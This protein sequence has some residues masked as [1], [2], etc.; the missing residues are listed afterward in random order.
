MK[1]VRDRIDT[2]PWAEDPR[3][4]A[5]LRAEHLGWVAPDSPEYRRLLRAKLLEECAELLDADQRGDPDAVLEEAADVYEVLRAMLVAIYPGVIPGTARR[6]L[7]NAVDRK[8]AERGGFFQG[9]TWSG[10]ER[11]GHP[12]TVCVNDTNGDGD[13]AA[14][15]HDPQAPCRRGTV[16]G[17]DEQQARSVYGLGVPEG[18][19]RR[20]RKAAEKLPTVGQRPAKNA[21]AGPPG[22]PQSAQDAPEVPQDIPE[23]HSGAQADVWTHGTRLGR[24]HRSVRQH[25]IEDHGENPVKVEQWSDGAV[26]GAHDGAHG[27]TWAYAQNLPH[28]AGGRP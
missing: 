8:F 3:E 24:E 9:R 13:C 27:V 19:F 17:D 25:L 2:V 12:A 23:V 15:A 6:L 5:R 1:L 21:P 22:S 20:A 28:P 18:G 7:A 4:V 14:C 10:P 11:A 16:V 26:H